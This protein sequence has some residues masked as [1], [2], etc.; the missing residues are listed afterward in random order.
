MFN[1]YTVG[2]EKAAF[3][4]NF[5]FSGEV[6]PEQEEFLI[7]RYP[8]P[9]GSDGHDVEVYA[10]S[11]PAMFYRIV[12]K[13][14]FN[15]MEEPRNGFEITTGSGMDVWVAETAKLISMGMVGANE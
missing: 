4:R 11:C 10:T 14:T 13:E 2:S 15:S 8:K 5:A 3:G 9:A 7:A 12:A 1:M 6:Y